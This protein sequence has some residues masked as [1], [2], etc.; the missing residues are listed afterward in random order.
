MLRS[1]RGGLC[2]LQA[3]LSMLYV[4]TLELELCKPQF[5]GGSFFVASA[6]EGH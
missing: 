5:S 2:Q 6:T 3:H 1:Q 4:V